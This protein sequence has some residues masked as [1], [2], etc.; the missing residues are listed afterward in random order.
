MKMTDLNQLR[1][2]QGLLVVSLPL[3]VVFGWT[4]L[5]AV[6]FLLMLSQ[7]L[8][9]DGLV[10]LRQRF[11]IPTQIVKEDPAPHRFARSLGAVFLGLS[12]L[13]LIL[14]LPL[15]GWVLALMV[16]GLALLSLTTQIC[17]GCF[18]YLHFRLWRYRLGG[19]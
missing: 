11:G 6:L 1:F 18:L 4:W 2:N 8:G 16:A 15:L 9:L 10:W 7:H 19:S 12:S 13:C 14:G 5:V 3:A 17:V